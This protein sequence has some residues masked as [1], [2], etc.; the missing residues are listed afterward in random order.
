MRSVI[1][2]IKRLVPVIV[3]LMLALPAAVRG[4]QP[5]PT[6]TNTS[7][8]SGGGIIS[9]RVVLPTG[10][11]LS[12]AVRISL[13]T[14]RG[15]ESTVFTDNTGKFE[16]SRLT[17]GRYQVIVEADRQRYETI[18][19][20]VEIIRGGLAILNMVLKEK[21]ES[22]KP[23]AS[24]ISATELD[25]RVP[26]KA[27]KEFN[28]AGDSSKEGK[29]EEAITHLR[30][31]IA[32]YPG[33][34]MAHN[35]LGAQLLEQGKLDEA[36]QELRIAVKIDP[37]AFNP[38]LN[39]GIVLLKKHD[40]RQAIDVLEKAVS[41]QSQSPSARL[42]FGMALMNSEPDRAEKEFITAF[43]LGGSQYAEALF[44]LG[45]I[46]MRRGDRA[47]AKEYFNRYMREAPTAGNLDQVRKLIAMLE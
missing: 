45:E 26:S 47:L 12:E 19:E 25:S 35:D 46:Y 16:F 10:G 43:D 31:A 36:E 38:I 13:Q 22:G 11:F 37:A 34:L 24:T 9:G 7:I 15:T 32:I 42:F 5:R 8:N 20:S 21:G 2:Y 18:S 40:T 29:A 28:R 44:H 30:N 27:R 3:L 23:K 6:N 41:I 4:Q 33:Y 1:S 39:L 14:I 17:P